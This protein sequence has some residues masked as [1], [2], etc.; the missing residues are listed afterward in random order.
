MFFRMLCDSLARRKSRKGLAVLA[1]WIGISLIVGF[2]TLSVDVG[3]KMNRELRSFGAN[4]KLEPISSSIPVTVGD[5]VLRRSSAP[6][7]LEER[8]LFVL[9]RIFWRHNIVGF[10]P[11]LWVEGKVNGRDGRILGVWMERTVPV[12]GG[13]PVTTGAKSVYEHWKIDGRWPSPGTGEILLGNELAAALGVAAGEQ[14]V[15]QGRGRSGR[16]R[17]SGTLHTGGREDRAAVGDLRI[18]QGLSGLA[19]KVSDADISAL[20]TPEN[21]LAEKF[22]EDPKALTPA[23]Y[24][25]FLCTPYP[26]AVAAEIQKNIPNSAARVIRRV[27]ETQGVVLT[28]INGLMMSL[29][30]L[31]FAVCCLSVMG[32]LSSSVLER[33]QEIALLRAVGAHRAGVLRLFLTEGAVLGAVGGALAGFSGTLLGQWLVKAVFDG[34]AA[35]HLAP[36]MIAPFLGLAI[37]C[38][39]SFLPVRHALAQDIAPVLH[40]N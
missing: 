26:G 35:M 9:K 18:V 15:L 1:I 20:T 28:R 33:R 24:E 32:V 23:E 30:A 4:I 7:Y 5:H 22:K 36:G 12:E 2:L 27:S 40:G 3:D 14:V 6:S 19:G 21:R 34:R 13:K 31:T 37:G 29:A 39:G 25:R 16:Y 10:V 17:V 11:R 38:A 8:D